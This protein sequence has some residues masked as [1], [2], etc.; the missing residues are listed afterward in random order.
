MRLV[1]FRDNS[2][3]CRIVSVLHSCTAVERDGV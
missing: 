3:L 1:A 2:G